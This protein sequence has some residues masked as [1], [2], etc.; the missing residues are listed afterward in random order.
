MSIG[1][2]SNHYVSIYVTLN[3]LITGVQGVYVC[4]CVCVCVCLGRVERDRHGGRG[5]EQNGRVSHQ[6][7]VNG[8]T[9]NNPLRPPPNENMHP[10][11]T[12]AHTQTHIYSHYGNCRAGSFE[13]VISP[14]KT[15]VLKMTKDWYTLS[16]THV[17][18]RRTP[19]LPA[20]TSRRGWGC[21]CRFY[22]RDRRE[23]WFHTFCFSELERRDVA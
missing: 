16:F 2:C 6:Q 4:V 12:Y 10:P 21:Y 1:H 18:T 15:A 5:G 20:S 3:C 23:M 8:R 14:D 7:A 22:R 9:T 19:H 11:T 17:H 13:L